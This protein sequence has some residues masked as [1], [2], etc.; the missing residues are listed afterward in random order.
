MSTRVIPFQGTNLRMEG[1]VLLILE[2]GTPE[3]MNISVSQTPMIGWLCPIIYPC[4]ETLGGSHLGHA[5]S[6]TPLVFTLSIF[7]ESIHNKR[8]F[9]RPLGCLRCDPAWQGNVHQRPQSSPETQAGRG[10]RA[11]TTSAVHML[12]VRVLERQCMKDM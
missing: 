6:L 10:A 1:L 11:A 3:L 5:S 2:N 8:T 12:T 4:D 7:N 9:W